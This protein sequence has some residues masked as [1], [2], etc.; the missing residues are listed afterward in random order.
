MWCR[1]L[2]LHRGATSL[3]SLALHEP[4]PSSPWISNTTPAPPRPTTSSVLFGLWLASQTSTTVSTSRR[5]S[6]RRAVALRGLGPMLLV[7]HSCAI[8][9]GRKSYKDQVVLLRATM[10]IDAARTRHWCCM[11]WAS[12]LPMM[13]FDATSRSRR[14]YQWCSILLPLGLCFWD[15]ADGDLATYLYLFLLNFVLEM[16]QC[17]LH[18]LTHRRKNAATMLWEHK[19]FATRSPAMTPW[20]F[21]V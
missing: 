13:A 17:C 21:F 20:I 3:G 7:M 16:L 2:Y 1:S 14:C 4:L 11:R 9:G 12:E 10:D 5:S 15:F 19:F 18:F 8:N 6:E